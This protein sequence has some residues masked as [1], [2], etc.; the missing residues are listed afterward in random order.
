M[1]SVGHVCT[2][3]HLIVKKL[4]AKNPPPHL[5]SIDVKGLPSEINV[6]GS[7][8]RLRPGCVNAAGKLRQKW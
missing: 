2:S 7:A 6:Q 5:C 4:G 8:K 3:E 1:N